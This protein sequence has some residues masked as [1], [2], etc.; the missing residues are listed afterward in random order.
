MK[1]EGMKSWNLRRRVLMLYVSTG[2][3]LALGG[4]GLTDQQ[5]TSVYASVLTTGLSSLLNALVTAAAGAAT[6]GA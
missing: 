4:C 5:L 6:T 3:L 1:G 2:A